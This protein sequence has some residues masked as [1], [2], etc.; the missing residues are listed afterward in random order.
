M[1]ENMMNLSP[2]SGE[3]NIYIE[4]KKRL[5]ILKA[6]LRQLKSEDKKHLNLLIE[7]GERLNID[8]NIVE[9]L[10]SLKIY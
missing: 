2:I 5:E 6:E 9:L 8:K 4:R 7:E 3:L 10:K 1:E